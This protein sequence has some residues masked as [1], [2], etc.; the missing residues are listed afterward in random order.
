MR[1]VT[2]V[3]NLERSQDR[4]ARIANN[5][6][7]LNLEFEVIPAIDG[8]NL[9]PE[10]LAQYDHVRNQKKYYKPLNEGEIGC[11]LSHKKALKTFLSSEY[12]VLLLLE[13]DAYLSQHVHE[14]I[15]SVIA[16]PHWDTIKFYSGKKAKKVLKSVPITASHSICCPK[17]VPNSML[18]QLVTRK[19]AE[20]ILMMYENFYMPA[21]ISLQAWWQ[22][23]LNV[24]MCQPNIATPF[25]CDS[26]IDKLSARK[27]VTY[28]TWKRLRQ[29]AAFEMK[30]LL[31]KPNYQLLDLLERR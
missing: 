4:L 16:K 26:E 19:G 27:S 2:Y 24:L 18:A 3:I 30:R 11:V 12:D 15:N 22:T 13:D 29:R 25:E 28:S 10:Q 7:A 17:K 23:D 8:A 1:L 14:V 31:T 20:K 21:D 6:N 5:L 9:L